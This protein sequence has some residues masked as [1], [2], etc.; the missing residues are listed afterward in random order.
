MKSFTNV[1]KDGIIHT[2]LPYDWSTMKV[3]QTES[4]HHIV[5]DMINM[6]KSRHLA[7]TNHRAGYTGDKRYTPRDPYMVDITEDWTRDQVCSAIESINDTG[8]LSDIVRD[9]AY[10]PVGHLVITPLTPHDKL[11]RAH[12]KGQ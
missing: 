9:I 10:S 11:L 2:V 5:N 4:Q 12:T 6:I 3:S 7:Q 1:D 8:V